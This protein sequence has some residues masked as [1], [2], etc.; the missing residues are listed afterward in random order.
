[1]STH[2]R[3]AHTSELVN[4]RTG[5]TICRRVHVVRSLWERMVGLMGRK[6]LQADEALWLE[7][8]NGVHTFLVRCPIAVIVLGRDLTVL[9]IHGKVQ[10]NRLV[11]PVR[12]GYVTI[13]LLPETLAKAEVM[14]GDRMCLVREG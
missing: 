10:P 7:P 12:C 9:A 8:C 1:M 2:G 6:P 3:R 11:C 5:A 4:R 14:L 13:E